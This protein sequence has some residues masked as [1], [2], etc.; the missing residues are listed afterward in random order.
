[1]TLYLSVPLL[2]PLPTLLGLKARTNGQFECTALKY[3]STTYWCEIHK[4]PTTWPLSRY[5]T[6]C[7]PSSQNYKIFAAIFSILFSEPN[8]SAS[9]F[10]IN[11]SWSGKKNEAKTKLATKAISTH[12]P[13]WPS[14]LPW[15]DTCSKCSSGTA[16][17][18]SSSCLK[19]RWAKKGQEGGP[20]PHTV[21]PVR[22][23]WKRHGSELS[24]F[25]PALP[26][27]SPL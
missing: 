16:G 26:T 2:L 19:K 23:V 9:N 8:S 18:P 15:R 27:C 6:K 11:Q 12:T 7:S 10:K 21:F 3:K 25:H 14:T 17:H 22:S 24:L 4:T 1:M 20:A 5:K 13:C